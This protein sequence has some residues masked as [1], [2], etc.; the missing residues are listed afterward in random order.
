MAEIIRFNR[1]LV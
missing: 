1:L